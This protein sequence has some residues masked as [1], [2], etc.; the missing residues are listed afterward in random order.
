LSHLHNQLNM[1]AL[2]SS[3]PK[4]VSRGGPLIA[5]LIDCLHILRNLMHAWLPGK[6]TTGSIDL[7][8]QTVWGD[9]ERRRGGTNPLHFTWQFK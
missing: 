7:Y 4:Q 5:Q 8:S 9:G 2:L 3:Q 6:V 1:D